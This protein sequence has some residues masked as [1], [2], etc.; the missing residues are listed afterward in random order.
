MTHLLM[1]DKY[2]IEQNKRAEILLRVKGKDSNNMQ[3]NVL[4]KKGFPLETGVIRAFKVI[5]VAKDKCVCSHR[6]QKCSIL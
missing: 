6:G 5:V 3:R 4:S 2:A 1:S